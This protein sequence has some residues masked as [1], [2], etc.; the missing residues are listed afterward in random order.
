MIKGKLW[1][2]V[3]LLELSRAQRQVRKSIFRISANP[4]FDYFPTA[5]VT[6]GET[7]DSKY[8]ISPDNKFL[9]L[10]DI[11]GIFLIIFQ[12]FYIPFILAFDL[13]DSIFWFIIDTCA[14]FYFLLDIILTF[15]TA[16]YKDGSLL[17]DRKQIMKKYL[18]SW[19]IIDI[20]SISPYFI[21][22]VP[23]PSSINTF[24]ILRLFR[25]LKL[26]RLVK[27]RD[28]MDQLQETIAN[29]LLSSIVMLF[30]IMG[31]EIFVA[32]ILACGFYAIGNYEAMYSPNVWIN[33][34]YLESASVMELYIT[35]LY[36]SI[37]TMATVG[38]GDIKPQTPAEIGF[39][40]SAMAFACI[41]FGFVIG[42][43]EG[44]VMNYRAMENKHREMVIV[45]NA[46]MRKKS[47]PLALQYKVRRY[48][49]FLWDLQKKSEVDETEILSILSN[50]LK[51]LVCVYSRGHIFNNFLVFTKFDNKFLRKVTMV[52]TYNCFSPF[53]TIFKEGE[54]SRDIYFIREG[55]VMMEDQHT[56]CVVKKLTKLNYF[57]EIAFFLS[58]PRSCSARPIS[59]LE[60]LTLLWYNFSNAVGEY[61]EMLD[62][63]KKLQTLAFDDALI[64]IGIEC[65]F[66][67]AQGHISRNC[68]LFLFGKDT[69]LVNYLDHKNDSKHIKTEKCQ[70]RIIPP[71]S[72]RY[73]PNLRKDK[74]ETIK[75][76]YNPGQSRN[77]TLRKSNDFS[78]YS[79]SSDSIKS[80]DSTMRPSGFDNNLV[81]R[82]SIQDINE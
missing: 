5:I 30:E 31:T 72:F 76:F 74:E 52:I 55:E 67:K 9:T 2:Q 53:D 15:N 46:F 8:I 48:M 24:K 66:C 57:G 80:M 75:A 60:T 22:P 41:I 16:I 10:W 3:S 38:Y 7:L 63:I 29:R 26:F 64:D 69:A 78:I 18:K 77:H 49:E 71:K 12:S 51:E 19:L 68:D 50:E 58:T 23:D 25:L 42:A 37:T 28:M 47:L 59:F 4:K 43:I 32:H 82:I 61:Q 65:Y 81:K 54:K 70:E 44:I 27:L 56:G 33:T 34:C 40:I 14:T 1:S 6:Q 73:R 45:M 20:I 36:W 21:Y 11:I 13:Y 17:S 35:A 62:Y 39:V 79:E